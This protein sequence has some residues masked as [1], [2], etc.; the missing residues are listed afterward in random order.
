M[1]DYQNDDQYGSTNLQLPP[2]RTFELDRFNPV[3]GDFETLTIRAHSYSVTGD[4]A[5]VAEF[6]TVR[7][8]MGVPTPRVE[9][10][11]RDYVEIREVIDSSTFDAP[12]SSVIVH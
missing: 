11:V 4:F 8:V 7:M 12:E 3:T 5:D 9:R 6:F 10:T 1:S 2:T